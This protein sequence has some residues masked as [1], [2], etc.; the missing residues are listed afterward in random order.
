MQVYIIVNPEEV[1]EYYLVNNIAY[2]YMGEAIQVIEN[3]EDAG[4]YK[5]DQLQVETLVV[6]E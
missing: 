1:G 6:V 5:Q 3:L 2:R 4:E